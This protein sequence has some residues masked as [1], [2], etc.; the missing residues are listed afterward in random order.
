MPSNDYALVAA[1]GMNPEGMLTF[2][3]ALQKASLSTILTVYTADTL[4]YRKKISYIGLFQHFWKFD[5]SKLIG[6]WIK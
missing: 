2:R 6:L 3:V 4:H 5:Y 1:K